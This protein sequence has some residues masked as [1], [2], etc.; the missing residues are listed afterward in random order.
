MTNIQLK[1][2]TLGDF[3]VGKTSLIRRYVEGVFDEKYLSTI[4]V[5]ISRKT[6][7]HDNFQFN[8]ILWDLAGGDD[9]LRRHTNYLRGAAGAILVCDLTRSETLPYVRKYAGQM[10][11]I[12]PR[13]EIILVGNKTDLAEAR[14]VSDQA[15]QALSNELGCGYLPTSAKT[16]SNVEAVFSSLANQL[17]IKRWPKTK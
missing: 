6:L 16:G 10:R 3:A 13:V 5:W 1:I 11:T 14:E 2:C 7:T 12:N 9:Y 4:G 17:A 15:M 8:L